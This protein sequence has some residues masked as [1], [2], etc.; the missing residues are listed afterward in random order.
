[1]NLKRVALFTAAVFLLMTATG[2]GGVAA[3]EIDLDIEFEDTVKAGEE[4]TITH[5]ATAV[6]ASVEVDAEVEL[7]LIVDGEEV[8]TKSFEETIVEG[9][10]RRTNFTHT[11]DSPGEKEVTFEGTISALGQ[12]LSDSVTRTVRVY[13]EDAVEVEVAPDSPG[14]VEID[15]TQGG[16]TVGNVTVGASQET[17]AVVEFDDEE[18]DDGLP[19]N[20]LRV[21]RLGVDGDGIEEV[22]LGYE[23]EGNVSVHW[24]D[25]G[26]WTQEGVSV[27]A[28]GN[29]STLTVA[30]PPYAVYLSFVDEDVEESED[31]S[32]NETDDTDA[33]PAEDDDGEGDT[34]D[35]G[36]GMPGF[37]VIG[38]LVALIA[39]VSLL[40]RRHD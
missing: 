18:P 30:E 2:T 7:T 28:E 19:E 37:G 38:T 40:R 3:Q 6:E 35:D 20:S 29:G 15:S 24:L 10:T 14:V 21:V 36:E 17:T 32:E 31:D 11:F 34:E 5:V 25:D 23:T 13:R 8:E 4:T 39:G 33:E 12:E 16:V 9:E 26:E 27:E 22:S 1:M